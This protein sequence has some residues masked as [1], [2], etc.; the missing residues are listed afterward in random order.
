MNHMNFLES[1][2]LRRGLAIIQIAVGATYSTWEKF[3]DIAVAV[4]MCLSGTVLLLL[5]AKSPAL[6][7]SSRILTYVSLIAGVAFL[8]KL[9]V[10]G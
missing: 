7:K 1:D 6:Q 5:D 9:L 3:N 8:V 4:L 2:M 10:M